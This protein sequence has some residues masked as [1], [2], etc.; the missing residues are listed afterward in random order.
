MIISS[1]EANETFPFTRSTRTRTRSPGAASATIIVRPS[2]CANPNPPG[3]IRSIVTSISGKLHFIWSPASRRR[4]DLRRLDARTVSSNLTFP[5]IASS[6]TNKAADK[7]AHS[8][9]S[10]ILT[11]S[12]EEEAEPWHAELIAQAFAQ[13]VFARLLKCGFIHV[14]LVRFNLQINLGV[15][16]L[17]LGF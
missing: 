13:E 16:R 4:F 7:S 6:R 15:C 5:A 8:K 11:E 10:R 17:K 9:A 2:A 1:I 14:A 3:R 12:K